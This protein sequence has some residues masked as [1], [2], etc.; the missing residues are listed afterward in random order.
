[1]RYQITLRGPVRVRRWWCKP[2]VVESASGGT[3]FLD[4]AGNIPLGLQVRLLRL[5]EIWT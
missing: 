5:L 2:G 1:M 4:E 3:V